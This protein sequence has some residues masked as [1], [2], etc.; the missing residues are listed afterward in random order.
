MCDSEFVRHVIERYVSKLEAQAAQDDVAISNLSELVT[1]NRNAY[2]Q[3]DRMLGVLRDD[4]A[5]S[6]AERDNLSK[7]LNG[8][9]SL[10]SSGFIR[11]PNLLSFINPD[12]WHECLALYPRDKIGVIRKIREVYG[13][14]L[15]ESKDM[16]EALFKLWDSQNTTLD[17]DDPRS[18]IDPS[19]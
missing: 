13:L 17:S 15:K 10:V 19:G 8:L 16:A 1:E 2:L 6:V 11:D 18:V 14:G 3:A 5:R 7:R 12:L 4:Y 9:G